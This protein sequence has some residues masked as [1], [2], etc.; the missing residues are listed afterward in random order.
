M[1]PEQYQDSIKWQ[2]GSIKDGAKGSPGKG[3][4]TSEII[5]RIIVGFFILSM[6]VSPMYI[7]PFADMMH[8]FV[9]IHFCV[10]ESFSIAHISQD[11]IDVCFRYLLQ[12]LIYYYIMIRYGILERGI[13]ERSGYSAQDY[14]NVFYILYERNTEIS[15][16]WASCIFLLG[17]FQWRTKS[18]KT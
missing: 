1:T 13:V 6:Y 5:K 7:H 2:I 16:I 12:A 17:L 9:V 11:Y 4:S 18:L 14:P 15:T 8:S 3:K 10:K